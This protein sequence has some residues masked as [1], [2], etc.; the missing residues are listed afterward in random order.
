MAQALGQAEE[1]VDGRPLQGEEA[2]DENTMQEG[3][4]P[5]FPFPS[6]AAPRGFPSG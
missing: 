1:G 5:V 3:G 4:R 6:S 2:S